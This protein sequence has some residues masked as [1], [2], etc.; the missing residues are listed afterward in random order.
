MSEKKK[1]KGAGKGAGKSTKGKGAGKSTKGKGAG[2]KSQPPPEPPANTVS[3]PSEAPNPYQV[4][5]AR[6][7]ARVLYEAEWQLVHGSPETR[8]DVLK[9]IV[10]HLFKASDERTQDE[11]IAELRGLV[12]RQNEQIAQLMFAP[13][14]LPTT[15]DTPATPDIP[16][17]GG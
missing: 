5:L 15:P 3:N 8:K 10:P 9:T 12:M 1:G 14:E 2:K 13:R 17:D 11:E 4:R 7:T 6:L 16:E